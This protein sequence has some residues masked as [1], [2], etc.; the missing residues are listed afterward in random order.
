MRFGIAIASAA[1]LVAVAVVATAT[2]CT[3]APPPETTTAAPATAATMTPGATTSDEHAHAPGGHGDAAAAYSCPMHPEVTSAVAGK[4]PRCGMDLMS[5]NATAAPSVRITTTPRKPKP[6]EKTRLLFEM[7]D[8][9]TK[10]TSF[11]VVH[12][13]KL[14]L[15]MVTPDLAWFAH[16]HPDIQSDGTFA[17]DFTFPHAGAFRL[18]TDFKATDR[19][20]A[21]VPVDIIVDGAVAP[22]QP[23]VASDLAK[24]K[25][26]GAYS[27]R[28]TTPP[29]AAGSSGGALKFLVVKDGKPVKDLEPYLGALG[30]LVIIN[31]DGKTFLHAHP[32]DHA[33]PHDDTGK[34]P[35]A[36]PSTGEVAFHTSFPKPGLY[37]AWAQ[38]LHKGQNIVADFVFDVKPGA[39]G[40]AATP[41]AH[42]SHGAH[43]H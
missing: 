4:C 3:K 34:P 20:A 10:L 43:Q 38:F 33:A 7:S 1:L 12:E 16:E 39:A 15:L 6:G 9:A 41:D 11:D 8:G 27:V 42:G 2:G 32:E 13:K 25:G 19:T 35:H 24:P 18:F 29:P 36:H 14:H 22:P 40:A 23:L 21:V 28:L 26:V 17:L 30:H 5:T 37:K 31:E